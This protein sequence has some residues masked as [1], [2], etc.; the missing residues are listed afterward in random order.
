MRVRIFEALDLDRKIMN[1]KHLREAT[2]LGLKQSKDIVDELFKSSSKIGIEV[3]VKDNFT[4][5]DWDAFGE[6][7]EYEQVEKGVRKGTLKL[8][9]VII[10]DA[11]RS[12]MSVVLSTTR[13]RAITGSTDDISETY[14]IALSQVPVITCEEVTSFKNGQV[15]LTSQL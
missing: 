13:E 15:L 8:F 2:G 6:W 14:K 3:H 4:D 11:G 1:I 10:T 12:Y 7:F 9:R 5:A